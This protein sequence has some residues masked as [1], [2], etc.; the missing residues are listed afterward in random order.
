MNL[1][2]ISINFFFR[3]D[4]NNKNTNFDWHIATENKDCVYVDKDGNGLQ[5]LWRQQLTTFPGARLET[6][7]AIASLYKTPTVLIN[8]IT[9]I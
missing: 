5:R 8:V 3:L 4:K 2:F 6:A 9:I 1:I 7:E